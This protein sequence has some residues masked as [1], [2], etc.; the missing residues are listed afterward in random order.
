MNRDLANHQVQV[1]H[2]RNDEGE[3]AVGQT[4]RFNSGSA[5]QVQSDGSLRSHKVKLSKAERKQA[6]RARQ[7][8]R[9]LSHANLC[10]A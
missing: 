5:Y 7:L 9:H 1:L 4:F 10:Q 6:K 2:K 3:L 8:D